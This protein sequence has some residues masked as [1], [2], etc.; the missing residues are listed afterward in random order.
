LAE[1]TRRGWDLA[2]LAEAALLNPAR[3]SYVSRVEHGKQR[4][5]GRTI[6]KFAQVLELSPEVVRRALREPVAAFDAPDATETRA[7]ALAVATEVEAHR[8][9][10]S[11]AMALALAY[12][13]AEGNA[14]SLETALKELRRAL[15][16]AAKDR[17]RLP[18]NLGDAVDA[19]MLRV[20]ALNDSGRI[21][22][23]SAA[24]KA[25]L[26]AQKDREA[27]ALAATEALLWRAVS[28]AILARSVPDAAD[29]TLQLVD[30]EGGDPPPASPA[31]GRRGLNGM[32][33]DATRAWLSTWRSPSPSH[34]KA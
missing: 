1:R 23:A 16:V 19:V 8:L 18:S 14:T 22:D 15:E 28:Q 9:K 33:G 26:A 5:T 27:E 2:V 20:N 24:L 4:M 34:G 17:E 29:Y 3:K 10:V 12:E 31:S 7:D 21:D 11:E 6:M 30:R 13:Y 25:A 32:S